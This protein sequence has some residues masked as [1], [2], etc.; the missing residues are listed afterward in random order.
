[1]IWETKVRNRSK[2]NW[3]GRVWPAIGGSLTA[4]FLFT[5]IAAQPADAQIFNPT[6]YTL[7]NGLRV[8]VIE[9]HRAPVVT[10]MVWYN[11]GAADE[12]PG[13]S[14]IAHF[15]EHL[16]FKG[17]K[18]R[19]SG[20][21]SDIIAR[22]GGRENA[23]TSQ[24]YT[25]YFQSIAADRLPLMMELEADRM[26]GLVLTD[27]IIQPERQVVIEER[28]SRTDSSPRALLNEQVTAATYSNH[29]YRLPVIGWEHEISALTLDEIV[30]FY[31]TWYAPNNAVLVVSGDVEPEEVRALA[32]KY[33]GPIP[34]KTLPPRV[35]PSEPPQ[36]APREVVL[37]DARV[38]QPSWSRRWLAPSYVSGETEHVYALE[39]LA[40]V[41][42]GGSSSRLYSSL[43]IDQALAVSAGAWYSP[44]NLDLTT[45][46][47]GVSPR[48]GVD[49]DKLT[50]ALEEQVARFLETGATAEEV[51]RAKQRLVDSAVFARDSLGTP[52]RIFGA[53]LTT[54]QSVE[55]VEQW[56]NRISAVTVEQ[57][58]AAARAILRPE[59]STTGILL[60][61]GKD[62]RS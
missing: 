2:T 27:D 4:I 18:K 59:T 22:N 51:E 60:P 38:D 17:T 6:T 57:V 12:P 3:R 15:L 24:D 8:V 10:H 30:D 36:H 43:V 49:V 23:F 32:E 52:A 28:R 11:V 21:F 40:Q 9:N 42:G 20:E 5:G 1:M 56:P 62:G 16:M 54:G 29:P 25:G 48:P 19:A 53:A 46:G 61:L 26:T 50:T 58:N 39:V 14:G 45:F 13:K 37:R 55:D 34:A 35:R 47:M 41:L 33:Y 44:D 7:D 31:N